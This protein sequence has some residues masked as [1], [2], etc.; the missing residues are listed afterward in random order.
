MSVLLLPGDVR[1]QFSRVEMLICVKNEAPREMGPTYALCS[2]RSCV[3]SRCNER[4]LCAAIVRCSRVSALLLIE[5]EINTFG[6][7]VRAQNAPLVMA[8][9]TTRF[10]I[11]W[12]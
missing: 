2:R 4:I 7:C 10:L 12:E 3:T 11:T 6:G 1:E 9:A 5:N 8:L